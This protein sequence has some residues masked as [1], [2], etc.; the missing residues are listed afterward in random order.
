[1]AAKMEQADGKK[2]TTTSL[3][4]GNKELLQDELG[5]LGEQVVG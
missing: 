3:P 5:E 4:V 1:M 2:C